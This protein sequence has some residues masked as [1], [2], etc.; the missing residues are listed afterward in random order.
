MSTKHHSTSLLPFEDNPKAIFCAL[1]AAKRRAANLVQALYQRVQQRAE[2]SCLPPLPPSPPPPQ[3]SGV[4]APSL[5]PLPTIPPPLPPA[6]EPSIPFTPTR[7]GMIP[8]YLTDNLSSP[9]LRQPPEPCKLLNPLTMSGQSSNDK[10]DYLCLLMESQHSL[11]LQAQQDCAASVGRI[12]RFE[13]ASACHIVQLEEAIL[14]L[15]AKD[16]DQPG[17]SHTSTSAPSDRVDLQLFR[18]AD[19]PI[20]ANPFQDVEAFLSWVNSVQIVFASKMVS[21]DTDRIRIVGSLIHKVNVLAFYSNQVDEFL[22]LSWSAFKSALFDFTLPPLWLTNLQDQLPDLCMYLELAETVV[23]GL[24]G[25]LI[26]TGSQ[27]KA[28]VRNHEL[29][30]KRLFRYPKFKSCTQLFFDKLPL[31]AVSSCQPAGGLMQLTSAPIARAPCEDTVWCVHAFLDSQGRCHHCTKSCGS[32][33]GNCPSSLNRAYV[34]IPPSFVTSSKPADYKPPKAWPPS[35]SGA[36]KPTQSPAGCAPSKVLVSA[37]EEANVVPD[38]EA[39][40]VTA[41]AA[42]NE[43]LRLTQEEHGSACQSFVAAARPS[44]NRSFGSGQ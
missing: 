20:Y 40:S 13:E 1:N 8:F 34:N 33:P 21:H 7:A 26:D 24:P 23:C 42:I 4:L 18:T 5:P 29:L 27:L 38:L 17:R 35:L 15:S 3:S 32:V 9:F 43:E 39:A 10:P 16:K 12:T 28:L 11:L 30:L 22:Q 14:L 2:H 44:D 37:V 6:V 36:G 19:G 31:K 41:F 25:E